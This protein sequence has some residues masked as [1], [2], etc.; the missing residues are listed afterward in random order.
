[1]AEAVIV[2][3]VFKAQVSLL[4]L[5]FSLAIHQRQCTMCLYRCSWSVQKDQPTSRL[6]E[7]RT[8]VGP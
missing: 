2:V 3:A 6:S 8:S 1:M 5:R 4:V 7:P